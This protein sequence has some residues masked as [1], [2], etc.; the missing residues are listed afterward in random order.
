[1]TTGEVK[2]VCKSEHHFIYVSFVRN[3]PVDKQSN[4]K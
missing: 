1:M 3:K 2:H 4:Y